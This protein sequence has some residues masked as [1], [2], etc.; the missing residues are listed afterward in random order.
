LLDFVSRADTDII[1]YLGFFLGISLLG[2]VFLMTMFPYMPGALVWIGVVLLALKIDSLV[3]DV[4]F[5]PIS[6]CNLE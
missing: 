4:L 5:Y 6:C 1:A 3:S 2:L